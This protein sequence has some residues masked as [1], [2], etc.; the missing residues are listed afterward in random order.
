M[1][2]IDF[3]YLPII[4][5]G[6]QVHIICAMHGITLNMLN[7]TPMGN[8]FQLNTDSLFGTVPWMKDKSNGLVLNDSMAMVQYLVTEYNGP[9]TPASTQ[10]A[11]S[12]ANLWAWS[13]D[14]YSYVLSPLHDIIT[15]HSEVFWR[16]LRLTD[17][18]AEGGKDLALNNLKVLHDKRAGFLETHLQTNGGGD[19]KNRGW[20]LL[21]QAKQTFDRVVTERT[22]DAD[23]MTALL[24]QLATCEGSD[25]F[26][27]FGDYNS[28]DSVSDFERLF[29]LHL[30]NLYQMLGEEVPQ[31]LSEV[32][33]HGGVGIEQGGTMRRGG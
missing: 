15:G 32:V 20:D 14:Y 3:A 30:S 21:S 17:S 25:W 33:S 10:E 24:R 18:L 9:L 22:F 26:W 23:T 19:F 8:D 5:R 6:E 13:N 27:W 16:N 28:G 11:A 12:I 2:E 7:S 31:V 4:G 29:R 1:K